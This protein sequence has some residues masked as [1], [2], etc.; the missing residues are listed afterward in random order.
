MLGPA[1]VLQRR[2]CMES[3][4]PN[5]LVRISALASVAHYIHKRACSV[6]R[7]PK[8]E[9]DSPEKD[10]HREEPFGREVLEHCS[11]KAI[12]TGVLKGTDVPLSSNKESERKSTI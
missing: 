6:L 11:Y 2:V 9:T 12:H 4:V 3:Y 7:C 1:R 10:E 8:S 5:P